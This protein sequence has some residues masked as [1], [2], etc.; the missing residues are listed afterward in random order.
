LGYGK[1]I[2]FK[3]GGQIGIIAALSQRQVKLI[4]NET[5]GKDPE[6]TSYLRPDTIQRLG[7]YAQD[8]RYRYN[9]DLGG[10]ANIAYS[11]G[12][13][14]ITLK[15]LYSQVLTNL[16][17]YSPLVRV[18]SSQYFNATDASYSGFT[19]L[20]EQKKII[21]STLAGEHRTGENN[22]TKFD[23]NVSTTVTITN[24]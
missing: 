5:I 12:H 4:E 7:Y 11:F 2:R 10:V 21:N 23:W 14:K 22:E 24:T 1:I 8:V 9:S 19:H 13:N 15:N 6:F 17:V 20:I 3:N 16:F 18:G